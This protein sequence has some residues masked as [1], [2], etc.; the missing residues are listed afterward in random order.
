MRYEHEESEVSEDVRRILSY[1]AGREELPI[2]VPD[3]VRWFLGVQ[4]MGTEMTV[5]IRVPG[6]LPKSE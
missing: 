5:T 3:I 2:R 1:V 4:I 6:C